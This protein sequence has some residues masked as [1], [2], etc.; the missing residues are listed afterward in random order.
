MREIQLLLPCCSPATTPATA[1]SSCRC[2]S[3]FGQPHAAEQAPTCHHTTNCKMCAHS[4]NETS[5]SERRRRRVKQNSASVPLNPP[6]LQQLLLAAA[7]MGICLSDSL[8]ASVDAVQPGNFTI[9]SQ[10]RGPSSRTVFGYIIYSSTNIFFRRVE[11]IFIFHPSRLAT[12][13][14]L[15]RHVAS[16]DSALPTCTLGVPKR[17]PFPSSILFFLQYRWKTSLVASREGKK[18]RML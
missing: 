7:V 17:Q 2:N 12:W 6:L 13:E 3:L 18:K 5:C 8:L 15:A 16:R 10:T 11:I 14:V 9:A 4:S 1:R